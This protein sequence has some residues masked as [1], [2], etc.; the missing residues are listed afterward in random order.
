MT[1]NAQT[2]EKVYLTGSIQTLSSARTDKSYL[3]LNAIALEWRGRC[4]LAKHVSVAKSQA[5]TLMI[6]DTLYL[7]VQ[8]TA[9]RGR[10]ECRERETWLPPLISRDFHHM[11][12]MLATDKTDEADVHKWLEIEKSLQAYVLTA[13]RSGVRS[14]LKADSRRRSF[15][16]NSFYPSKAGDRFTVRS[17]TS[18]YFLSRSGSG[19]LGYRPDI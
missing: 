19:R 10:R 4:Y 1:G 8:L 9:N 12:K 14:A 13:C 7:D 5:G 18:E 15:Q 3:V 2:T 16:S 11:H 6:P 17:P